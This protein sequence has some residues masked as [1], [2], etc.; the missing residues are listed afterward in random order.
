MQKAQCF[1]RNFAADF[2]IL[3]IYYTTNHTREYLFAFQTLLEELLKFIA[4]NLHN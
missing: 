2:Y 4:K 3:L 1:G